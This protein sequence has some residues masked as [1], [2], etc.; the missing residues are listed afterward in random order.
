VSAPQVCVSAVVRR[1]D[2]LLMVRRGRGAA[3]GE[4]AI[5]GGRVEPGERLARAVE[6]EVLEETGLRVRAG[7]L[8]GVAERVEPEGHFVILCHAATLV[9]A[10][11][12]VPVAGDDAA[13]ACFVAF[14]E[15]ATLDLVAG[16]GDFLV[17]VGVPVEPNGE[18]T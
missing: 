4:W 14:T 2:A 1:Q 3:T 16:L 17:A 11:T 5:P 6:R 18:P 13:A 7:A 8:L 15:V 12:A 9:D 10:A